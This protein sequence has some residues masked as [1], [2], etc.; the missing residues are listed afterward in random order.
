MDQNDESKPLPND[1][2]E[3]ASRL[4]HDATRRDARRLAEFAGASLGAA[5]EA[6]ALVVETFASAFRD[7]Q[8]GDELALETTALFASLRRRCAQA[9]ERRR[10]APLT[11][12]DERGGPGGRTRALLS[13]IRPSEREALLLRYVGNLSTA[14]VARACGVDVEVAEARV[15]RALTSL[16]RAARPAVETPPAGDAASERREVEER[17]A[18]IL[19]GTAPE[20]VADFV[21]SDDV[22]RDFVHDAE[23]L[24]EVVQGLE[25]GRDVDPD[26]IVR[27]VLAAERENA[28]PATEPPPAEPIA[29]E[30]VPEPKASRARSDAPR[31]TEPM[32]AVARKGVET[33]AA[34]PK[35]ARWGAKRRLGV[36]AMATAVVAV[37]AW[38]GGRTNGGR[39]LDPTAA[40]SG[41]IAEVSRA[42]G[43]SRG[44]ERCSPDGAVCGAV[45]TGDDLPAGS[46]LRTNTETR[47]VIALSDGTRLVVDRATEL[48]LDGEHA[49]RARLENGALVADIADLGS[50]R[51]RLDVPL[52][53]VESGD[54]KWSLTAG[55][56]RASLEVV[57]GAVRLADAGDRDVTVHAGEVGQLDRGVAPSVS[58]TAYLGSAFR[59]S[60]RAFEKNESEAGM[61]GLGEL[62]GKKPG[63]DREREHAV[64]LA[65]HT[66]RVRI[67]GN[68]ARTEVDEVFQN[69]TDDVLEGIFRFP[70]PAD[71]QI[72]R[73]ALDVDGKLED[74][75][76]VDRDRAA[77]IW[78]GAIVNAGAKKPVGEEIVW[79]PGPWRDPALL[80]W[81]RGGRF[82]LH[83]FPIPKRGTR[84]VVLAYTEVIP[85]AGA[86]RR[87]VYPLAHDP[88]GGTRI[89]SF[90]VDVEVRGFDAKDGVVAGGYPFDQH[91]LPDGATSFH[92]SREHFVPSGDVSIEFSLPDADRDVTAC[93]YQPSP[94]DLTGDPTAPGAP[95]NPQATAATSWS[96]NAGVS[97]S[98][99]FVALAIRPKLPTVA[100]EGQRAFAL[101]VDS[102]RSM[103]GERYRRAAELATRLVA[104]MDRGDRVT[105]L[106]CDSTCRALP[107]GAALASP[108][109]AE[110]VGAFLRG[111]TP[112]GGSDITGAVRSARDAL[113]GVAIGG[114]RVVYIGDGTPT[115]G[116]V[117]PAFVKREVEATMPAEVGTVTAVAIG[118]DADVDTLT[119][120]ASSGGGVVVPY[121]PGQP[122]LEAAYAVLGATY[123]SALRDVEVDVPDGFADVSPRTLGAI[124]AGGEVILAGRLT[125]PDVE[126]TV[127]L[128][129]KL[130]REPFERRYPIHVVATASKGNAFVPR[131]YAAKRIAELEEL[132]DADSR[133]QAVE[134][135]TRYHVASRYTSLLVLESTAMYRAFGV[136]NDVA[137]SAWTGEDDAESTGADAEPDVA[138][139]GDATA[140]DDR[141]DAKGGG[142]RLGTSGAA[143]DGEGLG[144]GALTG[145]SA[146]MARHEAAPPAP[147]T[148]PAMKRSS[149]EA[150]AYAPSEESDKA[151]SAT[152]RGR[153]FAEPPPPADLAFDGPA[154]PK[155]VARAPLE[156]PMDRET[157]PGPGW[158]RRWVPMR[159]IWE[160]VGRIVVPATPSFGILPGQRDAIERAE[161]DVAANASSRDA[162]KKLYTLYFM[163]GDV[164]R[165]SSVAE[166]WSEKDPL[167]PDALT[168]RADVAAARG[169]RDLAI[170]ILGSVVD[171]RPGDHKAQWRLARLHRWAERA[172]LGCRH[173]MAVAQIRSNDGKL[174]AEAVRCER[175]V[176]DAAL[177]SDLLAAAD[178]ATRRAATTL[179]AQP[180]TDPFALR[181]DLHLDAT[182]S[183]GDDLD[184][185][186][187]SSEGRISWLGAPTRAVISARDV[188]SGSRESLALQGA[189][190]GDY[191]IEITRPAGR[192]GVVRG[193]I[194][195]AVPGD[196][197]EVPFVLD[198]DRARVAMLKISS[199]SRLVPL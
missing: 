33:K 101:I 102:S 40:W 6:D 63:E 62:R 17:L 190:N 139:S 112:E 108:E 23:R 196:H 32:T 144:S 136:K 68:V 18:G 161:R 119:T 72:E 8:G 134:L 22:S 198:G 14:E 124:P 87:Y 20:R 170:R 26:A 45:D 106:A 197:R 5:S 175:D 168:A 113:R 111:V 80:E 31:A 159:K 86:T 189:S 118:T 103:F 126:G 89:G 96:P 73:L 27:A 79:V 105:V 57:R 163:S 66:T 151:A 52:G 158:S 133:R 4:L 98:D 176:G 44:L 30:V 74:G 141:D 75:A 174:L 193:M 95:Q 157:P 38:A 188:L 181:G 88:S 183:G 29:T 94:D 165:A 59:W 117:T 178:D 130:G 84:H 121:T 138:P 41:K 69:D 7:A 35:A 19:A 81:Q 127:V 140:H 12:V 164:E 148:A 110:R 85:P 152:P 149:G 120:L 107:S 83:V 39:N 145:A 36:A 128:R 154:K 122:V 173:S 77:S 192:S 195:I 160:R 97:A 172:E 131:L 91:A 150:N 28:E 25:A 1:A 132:P 177:A 48:R 92:L 125:R 156:V 169:D 61:A 13:A 21:S 182:W 93:A 184:L 2:D 50:S 185:A 42:F 179:L 37:F 147:A 53:F 90:D 186:M 64:E 58:S 34:E 56:S 24:V 191:V 142:A 78:R 67:V 143:L 166:R 123:G 15:S 109:T 51:A 9:L 162:V 47:A 60:E 55:A 71:A 16:C 76:F 65:S 180:A 3:G 137:T 129:G 70:L 54:A 43:D 116:A 187:V 99:P 10:R 46:I 199:R 82:E 100:D 11:P 135:S 115:I 146:G 153:A 114:A 49:R 171:V 155:E 167:D 194:E 104:E